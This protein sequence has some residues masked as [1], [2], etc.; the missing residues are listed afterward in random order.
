MP[1]VNI[2]SNVPGVL[3]AL[4]SSSNVYTIGKPIDPENINIIYLDSNLLNA[5]YKQLIQNVHSANVIMIADENTPYKFVQYQI[6]ASKYDLIAHR[7]D[8]MANL[9]SGDLAE[10]QSASRVCEKYCRPFQSL[11]PDLIDSADWETT[12]PSL[13]DEHAVVLNKRS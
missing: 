2:D 8:R 1:T 7:L 11:S 5:K 13:V 9:I 6:A 3:G 10:M 4:D 12:S